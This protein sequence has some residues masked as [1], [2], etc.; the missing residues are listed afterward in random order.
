LLEREGV[1]HG[2]QEVHPGQVQAVDGRADRDGAGGDDQPVIAQL[3]L[4]AGRVGDGDLPGGRVDRVG[5]VV[6]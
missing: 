1:G 3:A 6:K 5:G 4:G 2:V